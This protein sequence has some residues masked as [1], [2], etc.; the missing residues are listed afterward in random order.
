MFNIN[1]EKI[2]LVSFSETRKIMLICW[3]MEDGTF[4]LI[5]KN[6]ERAII[7]NWLILILSILFLKVE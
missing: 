6:R 1:R 7:D 5:E 2:I 4:K 3:G